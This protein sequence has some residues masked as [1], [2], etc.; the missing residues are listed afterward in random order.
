M[1]ECQKASGDFPHQLLA[2]F[3]QLAKSLGRFV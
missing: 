1:H 2:F 3:I